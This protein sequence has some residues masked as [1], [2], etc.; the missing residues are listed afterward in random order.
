[1]PSAPITMSASHI[2]PSAK[3]TTERDGFSSDAETD[4]HRLLKCAVFEF[5]NLTNASRNEGLTKVER[6]NVDAFVL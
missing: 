2:V 4:V 3:W 1:M 5:T 6:I